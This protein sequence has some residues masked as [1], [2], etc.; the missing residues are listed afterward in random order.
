MLPAQMRRELGIEPGNR[1]LVMADRHGEKGFW[2]VFMVKGDVLKAMF[3]DMSVELD[4]MLV[5]EE[6]AD[7]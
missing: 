4:H 7:E 3:A 2:K 6:E 1:L 5:D